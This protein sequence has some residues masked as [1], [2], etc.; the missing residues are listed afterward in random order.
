MRL[1]RQFAARGHLAAQG[2]AVL[3]IAPAQVKRKRGCG[4]GE[5]RLRMACANGGQRVQ[6]ITTFPSSPAAATRKASSPSPPE[7]RRVTSLSRSLER[8]SAR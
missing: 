7:K 6:S 5:K 8:L 1:L 3:Q 4:M 2:R